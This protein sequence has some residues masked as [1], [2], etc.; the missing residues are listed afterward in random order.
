MVAIDNVLWGGQ[1]YDDSATDESTVA[2]KELNEFLL[3]DERWDLAV[4]TISD[5]VTFLRKV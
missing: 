4:T 1:V 3:T 2:L 5:G